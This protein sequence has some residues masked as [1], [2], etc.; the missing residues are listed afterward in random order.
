MPVHFK[1][2]PIIRSGSPAWSS[3]SAADERRFWTA[4]SKSLMV[5]QKSG[6]WSSCGNLGD[7]RQ[8]CGVVVLEFSGVAEALEPG[9][10]LPARVGRRPQ[11]FELP[12]GVPATFKFGQAPAGQGIGDQPEAVADAGLTVG[13]HAE[14]FAIVLGRGPRTDQRRTIVELP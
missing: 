8:E 10:E 3:L 11:R 1:S 9:G 12:P 13:V 5:G 7:N 2:L 6:M 4:S 14:L